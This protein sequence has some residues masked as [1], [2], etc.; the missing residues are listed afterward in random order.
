MTKSGKDTVFKMR[1][2]AKE[3]QDLLDDAAKNKFTTASQYVETLIKNA[4]GK[5]VYI[6]TTT[7]NTLKQ[8]SVNY[9]LSRIGNN[10]NQIAFIINKAHLENKLDKELAKDIANELMY[11]NIQVHNIDKK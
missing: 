2:S 1:M 9:H 7:T 4:R 11:L 6:P 10:I 3:K 8:T 5:K